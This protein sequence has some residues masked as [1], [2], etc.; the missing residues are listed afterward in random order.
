MAS[1]DQPDDEKLIGR[2]N[3]AR[4][5]MTL[6]ANLMFPDKTCACVLENMSSG[7]ARVQIHPLP[8]IG[9]AAFLHC[10]DLEIFCTVIWARGQHCGLHFDDAVSR[11]MVLAVR[12]YADNYLS[13]AQAETKRSAGDWFSGTSRF[14]ASD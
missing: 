7:G 5:R 12:A 9:S 3:N 10:A 8:K 14:S 1:T 2:R 11:D 13:L 6:P 4:A